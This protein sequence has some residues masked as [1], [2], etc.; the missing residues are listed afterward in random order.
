MAITAYSAQCLEGPLE[1]FPE[2]ENHVRE[3]GDG[4][5][6]IE[7]RSPSGLL[8]SISTAGNEVTVGFDLHHHHFGTPWDPDQNGDV[9]R[10]IDYMWSLM[11][12][13]YLIAV[14]RRDDEFVMS[15]TIRRDEHPGPTTWLGRWWLK[16]CE[17]EVS[18]WAES[19][20]RGSEGIRS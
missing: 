1:E 19:N 10:A 4:S 8:L 16:G 13:E 20:P 12:G 14:W 2:F 11:S 18:G 15:S 9:Q 17:V 3:E 5:I 7:I 6:T